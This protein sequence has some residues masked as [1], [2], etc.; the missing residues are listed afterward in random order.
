MNFQT[1][2]EVRE[3]LAAIT[4]ASSTDSN[5]DIIDM[6]G[7]T[8]ATFIVPITD[9]VDTG[10]ATMT[11]EQSTAN[12]D[13]AMAALSGATATATSAAD[14]DLNNTLLMI[15]IDHPKE[16]YIQAVLTSAI[17][18]IAYGN[19]IV[20]LHGATHLPV[21]EHASIQAGTFVISPAEA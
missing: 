8:G 13:G 19:T 3:C 5:T 14:G 20:I 21:S 16:R 7:Y 2:E 18:N 17:A 6:S 9:S 10:V 4:A 12:A 1:D 11:I 15:T